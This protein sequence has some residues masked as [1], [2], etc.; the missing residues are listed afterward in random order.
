MTCYPGS[1]VRLIKL[2]Y[3]WRGTTKGGE[4][5]YLVFRQT[6]APVG[7]RLHIP[8]A[9]CFGLAPEL[10]PGHIG[11]AVFCDWTMLDK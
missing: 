10:R 6:P 2:K 7:G 4:A 11:C 3:D 1:S 8:P 5:P 9:T